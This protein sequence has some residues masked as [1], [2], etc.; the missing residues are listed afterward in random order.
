MGV[1]SKRVLRSFHGL[2]IGGLA[3]AATAAAPLAA[4]AAAGGSAWPFLEP[5]GRFADEVAFA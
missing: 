5:G 3:F 4:T 2:A 1:A